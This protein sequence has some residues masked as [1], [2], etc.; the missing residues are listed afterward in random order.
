MKV[1][2]QKTADAGSALRLFF[3]VE[4]PEEVRA[5]I[6]AHVGRLREHAPAGVKVSWEQVGKLHL[7]LKF[8]GD[9]PAARL[10]ELQTAAARAAETV[11]PFRLWLRTAGAFPPRGSPRVLWL[12]LADEAGRLAELRRRLEDECAGA[13]FARDS[14]P[15]HAHVTVARIR[16]GDDAARQ[17]K[18]LHAELSFAPVEFAV[19]GFV[20]VRSELGAGGSRYT[21]LSHHALGG[22][23]KA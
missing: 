23:V 7:T 20:L 1:E 15:F 18:R 3:A 8:L 14:R 22:Q 11:A 2:A 13:D 6:G 12:G 10:E 19:A 5:H 9:V 4:L 21:V 17:L 16:A